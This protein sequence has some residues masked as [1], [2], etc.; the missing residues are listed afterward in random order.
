MCDFKWFVDVVYE[1]VTIKL[2]RFNDDIVGNPN[3]IKLIKDQSLVSTGNFK[4]RNSLKKTPIKY[5]CDSIYIIL[6]FILYYY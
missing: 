6:D 3:W 5:K 4:I 2:F 1:D